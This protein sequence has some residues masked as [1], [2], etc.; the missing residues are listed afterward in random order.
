[1]NSCRSDL[2]YAL[3]AE[4]TPTAAMEAATAESAASEAS[5]I[6]PAEAALS[7]G[8]KAPRCASVIEA[9]KETR[10]QAR[11]ACIEAAI[12][13]PRR[14]RPLTKPGIAVIVAVTIEES[15]AATPIAG[16][17]KID[18]SSPPVDTP[19]RP[20]PA[21]S[22]KGSEAKTNAEVEPWTIPPDAR[23]FDPTRPRVNSIAVGY[24]RIVC[25]NV[26]GSGVWILWLDG[27]VTV[28]V[29]DVN[30]IVAFEDIM[31]LSLT[32]HFLN[33]IHYVWWLI[34]VSIAEFGRPGKI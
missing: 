34:V 15:R 31:F 1:M 19:T 24:P 5:A 17:A 29:R 22:P 3:C 26:H 30:L 9:T 23:Y 28:L 20:T 25:G 14:S 8:R 16:A 27:D 7:A 2:S 32:A 18:S 4:L 12:E 6:K 10:A 13:V 11:R 21:I 33:R